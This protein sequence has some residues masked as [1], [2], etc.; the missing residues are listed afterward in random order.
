MATPMFQMEAVIDS[1]MALSTSLVASQTVPAGMVVYG[2]IFVMHIAQGAAEISFNPKSCRLFTHS[3]WFR[4][5]FIGLL[6]AGYSQVV[7]PVMAT[8]TPKSMLAFATSWASMWAKENTQISANGKAE[9]ENKS[10]RATEEMKT[11]TSPEAQPSGISGR[12]VDGL[13]SALCYV[14]F[15][16]AGAI[17]TIMVLMQGFYAMG[18]IMILTVVGPIC[19]AFGAHEKTEG[20]FWSFVKS[21]MVYGLL[22]LPVLGIACQFA[23]VI[24]ARISEMS[25]SAAFVYG[26]GGD[27]VM[28]MVSMLLGP[29]AAYA[30]VKAAPGVV[31]SVIGAAG[32]GEGG[33]TMMAAAGAAVAWS[34][35]GAKMIS[36]TAAKPKAPGGK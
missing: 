12:I 17:I 26:D 14:L 27:V 35:K 1:V 28:Q 22:H 25:L 18:A 20:I 7:V 23:G 15:A 29:L 31:Q 33:S 10:L 30:V 24:M 11:K 13:R 21:A 2:F 4:Q 3:F 8:S 16:A 36:S 32:M 9:E 34:A 6:V 5:V 19:I